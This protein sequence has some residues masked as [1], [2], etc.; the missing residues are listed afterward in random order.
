MRVVCDS[1]R[2][3]EQGGDDTSDSDIYS[4]DM[5]ISRIRRNHVAHIQSCR[6]RVAYCGPAL[7]PVLVFFVCLKKIKWK[8]KFCDFNSVGEEKRI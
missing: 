2:K 6:G 7:A 3:E 4:S 5:K 1:K 8:I